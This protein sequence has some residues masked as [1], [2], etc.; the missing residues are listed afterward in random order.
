MERKG[1]L[2]IPLSYNADSMKNIINTSLIEQKYINSLV[3]EHD[4]EI[5]LLQESFNKLSTKEKINQYLDRAEY[6]KKTLEG[7][8]FFSIN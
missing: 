1:I 3:L 8:L 2:Y 7:I 6:L 4:N 5:R